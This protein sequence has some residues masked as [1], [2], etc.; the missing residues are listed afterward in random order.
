MFEIHPATARQYNIS[1]G[2]LVEVR[3]PFGKIRLKACLTAKMRPDTIYIPQGWEEANA[4]ELTGTEN[5]DPVSGF[6]NLKT[7]R[8]NNAFW[9]SDMNNG[10]G[11]VESRRTSC[12]TFVTVRKQSGV[13]QRDRPL[14]YVA[15]PEC[16][17]L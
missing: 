12:H 8:E 11:S 10:A 14:S 7:F 3:S 13:I 4:N 9:T 17:I 1:E 6:P 2:D 16:I 5:A 15:V